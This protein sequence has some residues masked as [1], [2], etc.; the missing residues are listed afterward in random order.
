MNSD[1]YLAF[2]AGAFSMGAAMVMIHWLPAFKRWT[3]DS[4]RLSWLD[5]RCSPVVEGQSESWPYGEHVA[6]IW[7]VQA[8]KSDIRSAID[9]A[10]DSSTNAP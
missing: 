6:N 1:T 9:E 5:R 4:A 8:A 10:M 7:A 3:K 2:M